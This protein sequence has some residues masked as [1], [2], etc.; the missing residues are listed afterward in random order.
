VLS[1]VVGAVLLVSTY[2]VP[3]LVLVRA[4]VPGSSSSSGP[5]ELPFFLNRSSGLPQ[6]TIAS[7]SFAKK[8]ASRFQHCTGSLYSSAWPKRANIRLHDAPF[9]NEIS[10]HHE[11]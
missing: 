4:L 11:L 7:A 10:V 9:S 5:V 6:L 1:T 8:E 3:A 2:P